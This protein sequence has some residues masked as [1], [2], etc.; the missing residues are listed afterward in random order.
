LLAQLAGIYCAFVLWSLWWRNMYFILNRNIYKEKRPKHGAGGESDCVS[1]VFSTHVS[2][3]S[4]PVVI[5]MWYV[6]SSCYHLHNVGESGSNLRLSIYSRTL[7]FSHL[8]LSIYSRALILEWKDDEKVWYKQVKILSP[9][10]DWFDTI[11][12]Y[13][14]VFFIWTCTT[15]LSFF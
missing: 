14:G 11:F 12:K 13:D 2:K 8:W 10:L 15:T 7:P 1:I 3:R 6:Y 9:F 4:Q 5:C